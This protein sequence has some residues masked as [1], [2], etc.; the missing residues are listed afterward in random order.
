VRRDGAGRGRP[1]RGRRRRRRGRL[2]DGD[3]DGDGVAERLSDAVAERHAESLAERD[4]ERH[5]DGVAHLDAGRRDAEPLAE[6]LAEPLYVWSVSGTTDLDLATPTDAGE[7]FRGFD[8]VGTWV[9]A[10]GCT[11]CANPAPL[12]LTVVDPV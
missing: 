1:H 7:T 2:A 12:F 3:A 9:L 11:T 6:L 10:L 5:A 4:A 8:D